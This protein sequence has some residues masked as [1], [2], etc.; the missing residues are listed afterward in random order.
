VTSPQQL[1]VQ[2]ITA[3]DIAP[4]QIMST[5]DVNVNFKLTSDGTTANV[6]QNL[7][8]SIIEKYFQDRTNVENLF[9]IDRNGGLRLRK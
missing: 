4:A 1:T 7:I 9:N 8:K 2:T 6:D 5:S 3:T